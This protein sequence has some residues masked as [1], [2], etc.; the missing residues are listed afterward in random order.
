MKK[1]AI[2]VILLTASLLFSAC[3]SKLPEPS[4]G[5]DI[6]LVTDSPDPGTDGSNNSA[7]VE[8]RTEA[9]VVKASDLYSRAERA[10]QVLPHR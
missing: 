10:V 2:P 6:V 5:Y 9:S 7:G 1:N 8:I 3:G 4:E